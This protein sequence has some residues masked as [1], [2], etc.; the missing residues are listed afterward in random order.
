MPMTNALTNS[1][2]P[3]PTPE[4]NFGNLSI[5]IVGGAGAEIKFEQ[6]LTAK[7]GRVFLPFIGVNDN[8]VSDVYNWYR[9]RNDFTLGV[10]GTRTL[11]IRFIDLTTDLFFH[12]Y[13]SDIEYL[14]IFHDYFAKRELY[15]EAIDHTERICIVELTNMYKIRS[16]CIHRKV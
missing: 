1:P 13:E 16:I 11:D 14:W 4:L 8:K 6:T 15:I 12:L 2:N 7:I 5:Q 3:Y 9:H 10:C